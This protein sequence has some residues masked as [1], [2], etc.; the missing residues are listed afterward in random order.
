MGR[1]ADVRWRSLAR[2]ELRNP[3]AAVRAEAA[4][5]CGELEAKAALDDLLALLSDR[6]AAVRLAAISALGRI[7]GNVARDALETILLSENA[8]EVEAAQTALEEMS[9]Y[10]DAEV[11]LYDESLDED[12]E[13][14]SDQADDWYEMDDRALGDYADDDADDADDD[15]K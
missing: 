10:A 15:D 7:G 13:L 14:E 3:S 6:H 1:S 2:A 12:D 9:Y 8:E 5:A 11:G 4:L